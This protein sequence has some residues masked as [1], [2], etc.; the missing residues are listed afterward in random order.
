MIAEILTGVRVVKYNG[1]TTAF[2][3]RISSIRS[4]EL[5]W[6]RKAAM[7]RASTSTFKV[8][9]TFVSPLSKGKMC[10]DDLMKF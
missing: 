7:L 3:K 2:L 1:W 8:I 4:M 5:R 10:S 6:I 9:N